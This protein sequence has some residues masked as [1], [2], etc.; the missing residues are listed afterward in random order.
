MENTPTPQ[1][2]SLVKHPVPSEQED[3]RNWDR[4]PIQNGWSFWKKTLAVLV[5]LILLAGFSCTSL[6]PLA[7]SFTSVGGDTAAAQG[8]HTR[9]PTQEDIDRC[10]RETADQTAPAA[11]QFPR[12]IPIE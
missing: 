11:A 2:D 5:P 4:P 1:D 12:A 8:V 10:H 3:D 7:G 9:P 6:N